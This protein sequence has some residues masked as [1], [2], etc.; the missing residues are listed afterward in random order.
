M[1]GGGRRGGARP[2]RNGRNHDGAPGIVRELRRKFVVSAMAAVALVL[3]GIVVALD[4][5]YYVRLVSRADAQLEAVVASGGSLEALVDQGFGRQ[6]PMQA[7]SPAGLQQ[8]GASPEGSAA[9][10][11]DASAASSSSAADAPAVVQQGQAGS[12]SVMGS[13]RPCSATR[14]SRPRL[15]TRCASSP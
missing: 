12:L 10:S 14:G 13:S 6:P 4:V 8:A 11:Q 1:G 7:Q 15:H 2:G 9:R 3:V 5:T